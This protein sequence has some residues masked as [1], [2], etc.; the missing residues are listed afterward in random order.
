MS[1][2]TNES[3]TTDPLALI[4]EAGVSVWLDDLSRDA[5]QDGTL[6]GLIERQH[7]VGVTTNPT[8]FAKAVSQ[9]SAYD[10]QLAQLG[11]AGT[12]LDEAVVT[13]TTDDV[14]SAC[15]LFAGVYDRT[16]GKDGRV[17]IEVDPRLA[18]DTEGTIAAA[19]MLWQ[20]VDRA[21]VM[22]KIPATPEGLP[23]ITAAIG[24]GISVNVTLIFSLDRYRAVAQAYLD[25]LEQA[26]AAGIDP[27]TIRSVASLFLSRIDAKVD[28]ALD[29]ISGDEAQALR[30]QAAVANARLAYEIY[31]QVFTTPRFEAIE[32]ANRQRPLWASTGTKDPAYPTTKYVDEL[33]TSDVVNTMPRATLDAVATDSAATGADVVRGTADASREVLDALTRL[34]VPLEEILTELEAEGVTSFAKSWEELLATVETGLAA[35]RSPEES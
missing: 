25:G 28:P 3:S 5:L 6:Q 10:D 12:D 4:S 20:R 23:A 7:V 21:N 2:E 17:S 9:G 11:A 19:S 24:A 14:R 31:E 34:G 1:T 33:V 18:H 32:G 30:G 29:E 15:D 22:I 27:S 16:G 13:L 8:I 26:Q 35:G